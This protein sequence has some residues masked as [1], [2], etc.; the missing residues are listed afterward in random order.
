MMTE[1]NNEM[2]FGDTKTA[3]QAAGSWV[4]KRAFR[5]ARSFKRLRDSWNFD[6]LVI[7]EHEGNRLGGKGGAA[8]AINPNVFWTPRSDHIGFAHQILHFGTGHADFDLAR[9]VE[10]K[11][12]AGA[13]AEQCDGQKQKQFFK[14]YWYKHLIQIWLNLR[15]YANMVNS[16]LAEALANLPEELRKIEIEK[17]LN[18]ITIFYPSRFNASTIS[19]KSA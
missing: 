10:G 18:T 7:L 4:A 2:V 6:D 1:G 13:T 11:L 17:I 15:Q 12:G 19:Q 5:L 3:L 9:M 16:E 8:I 14:G